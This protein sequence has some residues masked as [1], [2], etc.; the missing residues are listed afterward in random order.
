MESRPWFQSSRRSLGVPGVCLVLCNPWVCLDLFPWRSLAWVCSHG[1][2]WIGLLIWRWL[3]WAYSCGGHWLELSLEEI[4][5]LRL[6]WWRLFPRACARGICWL[7]PS[8]EEVETWLGEN[9]ATLFWYS[10]GQSKNEKKCLWDQYPNFFL[11]YLF[12]DFCFFI[13]I[14]TKKLVSITFPI[15]NP[16]LYHHSAS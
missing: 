8:P 13:Y 7:R 12:Y 1:G 6:L 10:I 3:T 2:C 9:T 5:G 4:A 14:N 15:S 16:L 11:I